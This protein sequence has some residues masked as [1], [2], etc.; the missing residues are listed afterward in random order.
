MKLVPV[1][2]FTMIGVVLAR[3]LGST[4]APPAAAPTSVAV[5]DLFR[6]LRD[7]KPF[8]RDSE[9]IRAWIDSERRTNLQVKQDAIAAKESDLELLDENSPEARK[10]KHE[11][12][13]DRLALQHELEYLDSERVRRI[14]DAQR[15]AYAE[16]RRAS[17][18]AAEARGLDLVL[19]RRSAEL[20]GQNQSELN[21]EIFLRDILYHA[22]R[23]DITD[24]VIKILERGS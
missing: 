19:Q 12:E 22:P 23:L 13:F 17:A 3:A 21:S 8:L 14:T 1:L 9:A 4:A 15:H 16:V 10:K 18:A 20:A 2:L 5:V 6:V 24:D 11:I 7:A